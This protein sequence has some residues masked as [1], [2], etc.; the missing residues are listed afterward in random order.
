MK[1]TFHHN[2]S[3][4]FSFV[5]LM[6]TLAILS[7]MASLIIGAFSNAASDTNRIVSRQQQAAV[8]AALN[9]WINSD[10]N[11]VDV[12]NATTGSAKIRTL[13]EIRTDYNSRSTSLARLNLIGSYLDSLSASEF[14]SNTI[15]S[16]KI[17]SQALTSSKQYLSLPDWASGNFPQV[18]LLPDA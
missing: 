16:G 8:Q 17:K 7:V 9:A 12:I 10:T 1:T 6:M 15:N 2:S 5:E 11:R 14:Y 4:G 13:E 3:K 18:Q